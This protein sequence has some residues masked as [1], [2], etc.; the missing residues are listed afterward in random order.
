MPIGTAT[1]QLFPFPSWGSGRYQ[2]FS[3]IRRGANNSLLWLYSYKD[4]SN[5]SPCHIFPDI[6][7]YTKTYTE[8]TNAT[9][10]QVITQ[11]LKKPLKG[12]PALAGYIYAGKT[13]L[14]SQRQRQAAAK[15]WCWTPACSTSL[16]QVQTSLPGL[17][18][19]LNFT[20][21]FHYWQQFHLSR[22]WN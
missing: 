12:S 1:K 15:H 4:P 16:W 5:T 14:D 19:T 18:E 20:A 13:A 9:D 22:I 3:T 11:L 6:Q 2:I 17:M 8:F 7:V 21:N 10:I